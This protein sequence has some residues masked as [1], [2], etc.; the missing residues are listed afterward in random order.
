MTKLLHLKHL[1]TQIMNISDVAEIID[2]DFAHEIQAR[3]EMIDDEFGKLN[4]FGFGK[5]E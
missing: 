5:I 1:L 4:N 2:E 3:I